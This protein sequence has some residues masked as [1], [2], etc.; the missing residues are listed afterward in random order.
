MAS[1]KRGCLINFEGID[2]SG[3]STQTELL[4]RTLNAMNKKSVLIRFPGILKALYFFIIYFF[5]IARDTPTGKVIDAYLKNC[6]DLDDQKIHK[7]FSDNRWE[8]ADSIRMYLEKGIHVILDRY[9]FSGVAFSASK[10]L[11]IE[12]CKDSDRGLP[13]PDIVL[14]LDLPLKIVLTRGDFGQERYEKEDFQR[15]V[16][17]MYQKLR[18]ST[19]IVKKLLYHFFTL[20]QSLF[21]FL[22]FLT[23]SSNKK[24]ECKCKSKHTRGRKG[25]LRFCIRKN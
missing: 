20:S 17:K 11:D 7:L 12:E 6:N 14:F 1:K 18:D 2:R 25:D 22:I 5:C 3:K 24:K 21:F 19:W 15:N 16:L 4:V 13:A 23:L 8:F 9:A 10:G